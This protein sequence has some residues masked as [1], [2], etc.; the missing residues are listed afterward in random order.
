MIRCG[1]IGVQSGTFGLSVARCLFGAA[2]AASA[3]EIGAAVV[4]S[5]ISGVGGLVHGVVFVWHIVSEQHIVLV[6]Y[7]VFVGAYVVLDQGWG[8]FHCGGD[9]R[10]GSSCAVAVLGSVVR[11]VLL[12]WSS[13]TLAFGAM[14]GRT[15]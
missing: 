11:V 10:C 9:L 6:R 15:L 3:V 5:I 14:P 8:A 7:V 13:E 1:G 4:L 2:S 12:E